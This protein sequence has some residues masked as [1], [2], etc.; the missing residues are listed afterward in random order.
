MAHRRKLKRA[1]A[2]K[3]MAKEHKARIAEAKTRLAAGPWPDD[4]PAAALDKLPIADPS[5]GDGPTYTTK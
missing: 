3:A 4:L 5:G 1:A 2:A